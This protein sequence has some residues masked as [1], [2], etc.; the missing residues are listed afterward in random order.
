MP[1]MEYPG[2]FGPLRDN[3]WFV[4]PPVSLSHLTDAFAEVD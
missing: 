1:D 2:H 4:Y 3:I